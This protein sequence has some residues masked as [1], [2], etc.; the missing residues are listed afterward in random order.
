MAGELGLVVGDALDADDTLAGFEVQDL[1]NEGERVPVQIQA[2][3]SQAG[4]PVFREDYSRYDPT[5]IEDDET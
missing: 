5:I 1:V 3:E 4:R 2:S